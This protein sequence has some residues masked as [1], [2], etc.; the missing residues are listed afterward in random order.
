[1]VVKVSLSSGEQLTIRSDS[2]NVSL[3]DQV[4]LHL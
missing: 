4:E 3:D 1:M 2:V